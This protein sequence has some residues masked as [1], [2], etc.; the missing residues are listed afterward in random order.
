LSR[1]RTCGSRQLLRYFE[2]RGYQRIVKVCCVEIHE[3]LKRE[4]SKAEEE[5]CRVT[6]EKVI[7]RHT[8]YRDFKNPEDERFEFLGRKI[9]KI[10]GSLI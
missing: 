9:S 6:R 1:E 7:F 8:G 3:I 2:Y 4:F 10:S 5:H